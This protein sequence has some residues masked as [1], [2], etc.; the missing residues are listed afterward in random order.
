MHG[1][2]EAGPGGRL[3]LLAWH[4]PP[5]ASVG[6]LRWQKMVPHLLAA[7][8]GVDVVTLDAAHASPRDDSQLALLPAAVRVFG[9][10]P[11]PVFADRLDALL[12]AR[13]QR[14]RAGSRPATIAV[15]AGQARERAESIAPED[16]RWSN[17]SRRSASRA[18]TIWLNRERERGW[19]AAASRAGLALTH[20]GAH[21]AV[22]SSGPPHQAHEAG[23]RIAKRRALPLIVD[24]RDPWAIRRRLPEAYASPL[25]FHFAERDERRVMQAA[26]LIVANTDELR[27]AMRARYPGT[28]AVT[29]MNGWDEE[30][31][32]PPGRPDRFVM[33]YAGSIY[34]DRDP[35]PL[36]RAL[37]LV[38]SR[39]GLTPAQI[40]FELMGNVHGFGGL[41][42]ET[43]ATQEGVGDYVTVHGRR[44][45]AEALAF[46]ARAAM[47]VSLPQDSPL[48]VPSKIFEYM[49]FAAW[50]LAL[51]QDGTPTARLLADTGADVAPPGDTE[52]IAAAI[53]RRYGAFAA[54]ER[55]GPLPGGDRFSRK[56]QA[57]ILAAEL[58]ALAGTP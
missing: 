41:T 49:P 38:V 9:V 18:Y 39:R 3:L 53:D 12:S 44:P 24:L 17:V 13:A 54:G 16:I 10:A 1:P 6:A 32:P 2:A 25:Y 58:A 15:A 45:R 51:A 36:L 42:L 20:S 5:G 23:L 47:L 31:L 43:L 22:I 46:L 28:R 26:R 57:G 56:T 8:W 19:V 27:D 40:G 34:L 37:A 50:L 52:R 33:A 29:V 4:F 11:D 7:G 35:K 14:A 48:A 21:R 30:A 55:P